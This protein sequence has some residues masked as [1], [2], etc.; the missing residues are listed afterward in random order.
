MSGVLLLWV[1]RRATAAL[2]ELAEDYRRRIG[3]HVGIEEVRIR[4]VAGRAGDAARTLALEAAAIRRHLRPSDHVVALDERGRERTSEE[5]SRWL[6]GLLSTSRVAFV[7]G[8]DLGLDGDLA[9]QAHERLSL[10]RLTLPHQL[11]R[12]LLLE[13]LYRACDIAAGGAYH[14]GERGTHV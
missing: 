8:S 14:R 3:R 11:A 5:L 12:V 10:S 2:E 1:G 13:Q 6:D 9:T 4:P 7:I